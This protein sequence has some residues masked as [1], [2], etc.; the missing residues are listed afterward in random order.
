MLII[1]LKIVIIK[2]H[3]GVRITLDKNVINYIDGQ[4]AVTLDKKVINYIDG[5]LAIVPLKQRP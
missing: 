1:F 4:L 2:F 3:Y 5:Q